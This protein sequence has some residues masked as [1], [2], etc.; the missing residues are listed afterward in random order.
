MK[1][2]ATIYFDNCMKTFLIIAS[3]YSPPINTDGM[4]RIQSVPVDPTKN[5]C[6]VSKCR[7]KWLWPN[8]KTISFM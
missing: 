7:R 4:D 8:I 6:V 5:R 1:F 3:I 2:M